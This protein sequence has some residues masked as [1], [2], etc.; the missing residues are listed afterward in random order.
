MRCSWTPSITRHFLSLLSDQGS[1]AIM[2]NPEKYDFS[3]EEIAGTFDLVGGDSEAEDL[4]AEC[5]IN[6]L[7]HCMLAV[8]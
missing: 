3:I 7:L 5:S 6:G 4:K 8:L 1:D 2:N